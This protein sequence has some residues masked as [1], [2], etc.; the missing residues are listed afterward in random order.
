MPPEALRTDPPAGRVDA[1]DVDEP[2]PHSAR[3][4]RLATVD[5]VRVELARVYRET[6]G[7]KLAPDLGSKLTYMLVQLARVTEVVTVEKR[8][9]EIEELL[10]QG[11]RH[12][13]EQHKE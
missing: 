7:L 3:F 4:I 5:D 6:R 10:K 8:L 2:T 11:V 9:R 1:E 13:L 12:G